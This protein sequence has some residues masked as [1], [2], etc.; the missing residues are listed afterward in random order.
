MECYYCDNQAG[1]KPHDPKCPTRVAADL[2]VFKDRHERIA[3]EVL[4]A[5][6]TRPEFK[7]DCNENKLISL[8][9]CAIRLAEALVS[10]IDKK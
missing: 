7:A 4:A 10:E 9:A 8:V 1:Y 5:F 3:A 2:I 6:A